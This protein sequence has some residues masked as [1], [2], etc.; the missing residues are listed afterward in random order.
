[1]VKHFPNVVKNT[2]FRSN[3]SVNHK[4]YKEK[5]KFLSITLLKAKD[6]MLKAAR[7]K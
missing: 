2:D 1:M 4:Q 7:E 6:K 5:N 3:I